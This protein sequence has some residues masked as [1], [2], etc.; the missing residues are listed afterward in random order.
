MKGVNDDTVK[1]RMRPISSVTKTKKLK[2]EISDYVII[3]EN[4]TDVN[5][6]QVVTRPWT[7]KFTKP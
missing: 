1:M 6:N 5:S 3:E 7:S 2:N 4:K